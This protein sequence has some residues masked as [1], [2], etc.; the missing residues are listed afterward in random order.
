MCKEA[1]KGIPEDFQGFS[2]FFVGFCV[3]FFS[4]HTADIESGDC[5]DDYHINCCWALG[6]E[7]AV[8]FVIFLAQFTPKDYRCSAT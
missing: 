6:F 8:V 2:D 7:V 5:T 3:G 4:P 1:K